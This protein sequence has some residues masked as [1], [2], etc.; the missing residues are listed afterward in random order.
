M[1]K[2]MIVGCIFIVFMLMLL[3]STTAV[4]LNTGLERM[5]WFSDYKEF[6]NM[7][8]DELT[9]FIMG[10]IQENSVMQD[11]FLRQIEE[12]QDEDM[13]QEKITN[14]NQSFIQKIWGQVLNY[15]LFRLYVSF[16]I[17][18]YLQLKITIVRTI[19]WAI[20][21]LRWINIG[22]ILGIVDFTPDGPSETPT[23]MFSMDMENNTLTVTNVYPDDTMWGDIDQIGSG[24][25]NPLPT[26]N[27]SMGDMITNCLGIIVLRY[28]P[29]NEVLGVFEFE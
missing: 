24:T 3:P 12:M 26:G 27:V 10:L 8:I 15:R 7:N 2:K 21:V 16:M 17:S 11:D 18:V 6:Q 5:T 20:R 19:S 25:S 14:S 29:T 9:D 28:V 22:I 13:L 23:I 1:K 4:Q